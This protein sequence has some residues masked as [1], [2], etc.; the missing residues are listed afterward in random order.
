MFKAIKEFRRKFMCSGFL[1]KAHKQHMNKNFDAALGTLDR[2][3]AMEPPSFLA[4]LVLCERGEIEYRLGRYHKSIENLSAFVVL[5]EECQVGAKSNVTIN[6]QIER[7]K[8][9]I[10][11]AKSK[12]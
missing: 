5:A 3:M 12:T 4:I 11:A 1:G 6:R 7:A 2:I 10:N 9:F 8:Q